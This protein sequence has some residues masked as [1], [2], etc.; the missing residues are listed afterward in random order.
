MSAQDEAPILADVRATACLRALALFEDAMR[1]AANSTSKDFRNAYD[2]AWMIRTTMRVDHSGHVVAHL[3]GS[4]A[5]PP[6][7]PNED[8]FRTI[9]RLSKQ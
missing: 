5:H 2:H 4:G 1:E 3:C 6:Q 9:E 8:V 7:R